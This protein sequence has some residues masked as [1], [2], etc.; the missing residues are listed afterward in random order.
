MYVSAHQGWVNVE[1]PAKLNLFLEVLGKRP[2]GYHE[3][4]THMTSVSVF[5]SL[6]LR[7]TDD[8]A[9]RL[10]CRWASGYLAKELSELSQ[11]KGEKSTDCSAVST[12]SEAST[13]P[14]S[15]PLPSSPFGDLPAPE[16]NIITRAVL[17]LRELS[18]HKQG[19]EI[20]VTKRIASVAGLG[21]ASAD[22]VAALL[23]ANRAWNLHWPARQLAE[24]AA[25]VGSDTVFFLA[26]G[27]AICRGRG[28]QVSSLK[29][30]RKQFVIVRPPVGL[31]TP[32]VFSKL[33]ISEHPRAIGIPAEGSQQ[34][35]TRE[36]FFNRLEEPA[37]AATPWIGKLRS[38]MDRLGIAQHQ[39]TGSGSSY[40][41]IARSARHARRLAS[42]LR[43]QRLGLVYSSASATAAGFAP[44]AA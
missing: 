18:G 11:S 33:K 3:L 16:K 5:D 24:V 37:A 10:H 30:V 40:F 42:C 19:C 28:E 4:I 21:G 12:A 36:E 1:A 29:S 44:L 35:S 6:R 32:L 22:A 23:A 31:S 20:L 17:K 14:I 34:S 43:A 39:M 25:L 41:G 13:S 26:G 2:D 15:P 8:P 27:S 7:A 9:I 38:A